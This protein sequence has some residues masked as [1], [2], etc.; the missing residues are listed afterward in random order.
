MSAEI[1]PLLRQNATLVDVL[2]RARALDLPD[3]YVTAGAV[4]QTVWN[5]LTGRP[6]AAGSATT[7]SP[8]TTPPTSA[9][10]PRTP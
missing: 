2:E 8:T 1:E 10:R 3:W 7:T 5:A 6:A 4:Y 9:G